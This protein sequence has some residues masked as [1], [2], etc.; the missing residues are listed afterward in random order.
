MKMK[1][2]ILAAI[3]TLCTA[4]VASAT[5]VTS[6][7]SGT[8]VSVPTLNYFGSGPVTIAPGI[9]VT[10]TNSS[11]VFGYNG[12]YGFAT[13]GNWDSLMNM[14][15]LNTTNGDVTFSFAAPLNGVGGFLNYAPN[16]GPA[17]TISVYDSGKNLLESA[18]LSFNTGGGADTGRFYGFNENNNISYF[19]IS[20]SYIGLTNLTIENGSAPVPEPGTMA[21]LGLGMTGLAIFGKRRNSKKA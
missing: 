15:G 13:N 6:L 14:E 19:S 18:T 21:L 7:P 4:G 12:G 2:M 3:L 9:S 17:P 1:K 5:L 8:A 11:A 16:Y 20:N 10:S